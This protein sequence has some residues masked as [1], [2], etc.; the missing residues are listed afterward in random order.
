MTDSADEQIH[1]ATPNR[2]LQARRDGD[3][4]KSFELAAAIQMIGAITASYLLLGQV[5]HWLRIWTSTTWREAGT[6]IDV[7]SADITQQIQSMLF[8]T[9]SVLLP[10][11][12]LLMFVGVGSHWIQTGP[13]FLPG[14]VAPDATRIASG[15]WRR[16]VFSISGIASLII[17]IPKTLVAAIAVTSSVYIKRNEF[18]ALSN[19]SIDVMVSAIF[20]LVLTVVL[21]VALAML[22]VSMAD[23]GLKRLSHRK[24]LRMTDQQL[25]DEMRMESGDPQVRDRQRRTAQ[26]SSEPQSRILS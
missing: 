24:R 7:T 26:T 14:R 15:N 13:L 4:A 20:S 12:A 21:H 11:M 16:H 8:S 18:L 3:I 1:D 25:R 10:L 9:L 5:G 19:Y 17:G 23:Y 2:Q 22:V 6:R